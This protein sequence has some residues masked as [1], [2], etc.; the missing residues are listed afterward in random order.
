MILFKRIIPIFLPLL[1][2]VLLEVPLFK[3]SLV[4]YVVPSLIISVVFFTS[5]LLPRSS[6]KQLEIPGFSRS[7]MV[8][9]IIILSNPLLL[10]LCSLFFLIFLE[11]QWLHHLIVFAVSTIL[12]IYLEDVF[13]YSFRPHKY[14]I[15]SLENI[16]NYL[17]LIT[18]FFFYSGL[19]SLSIFLK[20]E[21]FILFFG[22]MAVTFVLFLQ[23]ISIYGIFLSQSWRHILVSILIC[24]EVFWALG[25]LPSSFYVN[26]LILTS[27]F[28]ITL[29]INRL[30]LIGEFKKRAV[31]R[32]LIIGLVVI[33]LTFGTARWT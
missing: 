19:Y 12:V 26:G 9:K 18:A 4:F 14:Q 8:S 27:V 24:A 15:Y 23:N 11:N 30:Y 17:S 2:F 16:S 32:Y 31:R 7:T 25:F 10:V 29:N 33:L 20:V 13:I 22:L 28:Y 5:G 3:P 21:T 6:K 1:V